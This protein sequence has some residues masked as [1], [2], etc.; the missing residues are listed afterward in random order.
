MALYELALM[1]SPSTDHVDGLKQNIE[2]IVKPFGLSLGTEIGW[3]VRPSIFNPPDKALAAVAFF[4]GPGVSD[5]GLDEVFRRGI[6]ILPVVS[7]LERHQT[8][9]PSSLWNLNSISYESEGAARVATAVLECVGLLPRQ[10]RVFISYRRE[11]A[12]EVALQLFDELSARQFD[13]L[14]YAWCPARR[15]LPGHVMASPL[16]F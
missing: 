8:E 5:T 7:K 14:R 2:D 4:V 16:R 6:P 1:G 9:T 10:R 15:R 11:E 12:R 13:V 3:S